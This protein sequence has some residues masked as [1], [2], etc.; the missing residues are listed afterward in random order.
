[1]PTNDIIPI[2]AAQLLAADIAAS[3][4]PDAERWSRE[5]LEL[6]RLLAMHRRSSLRQLV[7][8]GKMRIHQRDVATLEA[9]DNAI[10]RVARAELEIAR[11]EATRDE[12]GL[13]AAL[14]EFDW[15]NDDMFEITDAYHARVKDELCASQ[16]T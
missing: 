5:V 13:T 9:L 11:C 14:A 12:A 8:R 16:Q 15:A 3:D 2:E 10:K 6:G 1:M 4:A 7:H